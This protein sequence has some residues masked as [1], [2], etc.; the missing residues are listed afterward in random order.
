MGA[1]HIYSIISCIHATLKVIVLVGR[2]V[3]LLVGRG[4]LFFCWGFSGVVTAH[5]YATDTVMY[6]ALYM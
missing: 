1:K 5:L 4:L 6:M 3:G 2:L